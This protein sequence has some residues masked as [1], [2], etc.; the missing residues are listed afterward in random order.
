M[1]HIKFELLLEGKTVGY[2]VHRDSSYYNLPQIRIF[3][4]RTDPG[5]TAVGMTDIIEEK[6]KFIRHDQKKILFSL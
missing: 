2:E 4:S 5:N 1:K 3:H 6:D